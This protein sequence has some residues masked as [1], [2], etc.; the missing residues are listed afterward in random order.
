MFSKTMIYA[1]LAALVSG[2]AAVQ[3]S[4]YERHDYYERRGPMPFEVLDLDNDGVVT[5]EEHD[6]VRTERRAVRAEQ[7]Y[8]MRR[9]ASAPSFDQID[10]NGNGAIDRAELSAWQADRARQRGPGLGS[11]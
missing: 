4:D 3:A 9:S 5:A 7:G 10:A 2:S 8:P 6:K 11:R 1:A